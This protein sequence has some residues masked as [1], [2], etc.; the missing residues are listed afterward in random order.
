[1]MV[2][3]ITIAECIGELSQCFWGT[4]SRVEYLAFS[5]LFKA[6]TR[7]RQREQLQWFPDSFLPDE[8]S[9][10]FFEDPHHW[11]LRSRES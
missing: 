2:L 7:N 1:M 5:S 6:E 11:N 10:T 8:L 4:S 3:L 9:I